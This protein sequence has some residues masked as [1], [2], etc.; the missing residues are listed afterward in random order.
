MACRLLVAIKHCKTL[1]LAVYCRVAAV[2]AVPAW[3]DKFNVLF[4][5]LVFW[6]QLI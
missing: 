5:S 1:Q 3:V 2:Q 6:Y 4:W